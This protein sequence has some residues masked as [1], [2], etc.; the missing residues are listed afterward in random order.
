MGYQDREYYQDSFGP[1]GFPMGGELTYTYRIV[2]ANA[3]VFLANIVG[4]IV[5][6][7]DGN[8][9]M[10]LLAMHGDTANHPLQWYQFL[11]YGFAH[12]PDD[13]GHLFWNMFGLVIFGSEIERVYGKREYL[14]FYLA[15]VLF[16][17]LVWGLRVYLGHGQ[18]WAMIDERFTLHAVSLVGASGAVV[19]TT[20]LFCLR[21]PFATLRFMLIIPI[22]AWAV[23]VI[24]VVGDLMN[25]RAGAGHTVAHDVHL[26]GALFAVAYYMFNWRLLSFTRLDWLQDWGTKVKQ[27][28]KS[29][30]KLKV[31][32]DKPDD[33]MH[34][35]LESKADRILQK[36]AEHGETSL[37][38][39]ERTTLERYSRMMRQKRG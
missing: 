9:L 8:R 24:I 17:G 13:I 20:I 35:D 18:S 21:N 32:D 30:P 19:A 34:R 1:R 4:N 3:V 22:P 37:S 6:G 36:I 11:T 31:Y 10:D 2:I 28:A 12:N 15:A 26:A 38:S 16:G 27:L 33:S 39:D 7:D 29:R 23:G 25:G 14:R 5:T